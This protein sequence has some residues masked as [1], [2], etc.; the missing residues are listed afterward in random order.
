MAR[1]AKHVEIADVR[2][3]MRVRP[4]AYDLFAGV[5]GMSLGLE[6]AGFDVAVAVELNELTGRY[7][8]FNLPA[9]RVLFGQSGDVRRIDVEKLRNTQPD[10]A[11]CE[12]AL[13]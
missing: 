11:K 4:L 13:I 2:E 5:G 8:Q 10:R 7:A 12:V 1:S 6:K 9:T 3:V